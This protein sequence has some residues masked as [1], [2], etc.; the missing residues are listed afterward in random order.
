[1]KLNKDK[2]RQKAMQIIEAFKFHLS[3][4]CV[5]SVSEIF[6]GDAPHDPKGCVAQ[7]WAVAEIARV[8]K[9]YELHSISALG[10]R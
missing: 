9:E 6:D 8:I 7:A 10:L 5:G 3:E 4:A 2:C 1:M